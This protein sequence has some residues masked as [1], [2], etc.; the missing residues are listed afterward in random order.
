M[1]WLPDDERILP[2]KGRVRC[3]LSGKRI[4]ASRAFRLEIGGFPAL[5]VD[6]DVVSLYHGR[7]DALQL[8]F[9]DA[10]LDVYGIHYE[11]HGTRVN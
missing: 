5:Y 10:F 3:C 2:R 9:Q 7:E 4:V 8:R 1:T 6:P 11:F